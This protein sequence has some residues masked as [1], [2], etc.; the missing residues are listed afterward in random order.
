MNKPLVTVI[1]TTTGKDSLDFL[2]DSIKNQNIP[3]KHILLWNDIRVGKFLQPQITHPSSLEIQENNYSCNCIIIN[4]NITRSSLKSIGL[5]VA[6][7]DIVTFADD[8]VMWEPNHLSSMLNLMKS[9]S[10]AYCKRRVWASLPN[11][12]YEYLGV[13]EF[14][15]MGEEA[16]TE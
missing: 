16:K 8:N 5:M 3:V 12:D 1:T 13:D 10:W 7:T 2:I 6:N 9:S 14:E 11:K 4:G 15:S